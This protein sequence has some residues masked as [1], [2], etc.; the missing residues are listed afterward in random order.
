MRRTPSTKQRER[1]DTKADQ[2]TRCGS[3]RPP[4]ALAAVR[5]LY[6]AVAGLE[7]WRCG[8]GYGET[9]KLNQWRYYT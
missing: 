5:L 7:R 3:P 8:Y 9:S 1:T 6:H 4:H 2:Q